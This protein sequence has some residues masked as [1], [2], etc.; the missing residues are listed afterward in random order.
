MQEQHNA[1]K[2]APAPSSKAPEDKV[3]IPIKM[4]AAL[5]TMPTFDL[6]RS[7]FSLRGPTRTS[8]GA[9]YG[10][11][12]VSRLWNRRNVCGPIGSST[13]SERL[14]CGE[15]RAR[16]LMLRFPT[17]SSEYQFQCRA[18]LHRRFRA[19]PLSTLELHGFYRE[20][21]K[22]DRNHGFTRHQRA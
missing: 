5:A 11:V 21:R 18:W 2:S 15:I 8:G 13:D 22:N 10:L 17:I 1:T 19:E 7:D 14:G 12:M 6:V 3:A 16:V 4:K 9:S 20:A